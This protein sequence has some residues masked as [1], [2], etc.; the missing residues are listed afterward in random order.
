MD[1]DYMHSSGSRT[2]G[3]GVVFIISV[4]VL[5]QTAPGS[6]APLKNVII[7]SVDTLRADH[8]G[9]Y[10]YP[11]NTSPAIDALSKDGVLF[12]RCFT[13]TPLTTPAFSTML[14]SLSPHR[15]GAK[16]NGLSIFNQIHTLPFYLK[17]HGITSAAFISNWP[18]RK[19]LCGL[20]RDF[21]S[22]TEVF[23]KRRW[24]GILN[25]E[26]EAQDVTERATAWLE[27]NHKKPLF[28]WV[29]FTD[30]HAPYKFHRQHV[31]KYHEKY[32]P[33]YPPGTHYDKIE[34]YDSEIALTDH[35]IGKLLEKIRALGLYRDT[36]I[37][38]NSDHGE[39][40]GEHNYFRHGRKLYNSTLHIPLIVKYPGNHLGGTERQDN[41]CLL[42]IAP[43]ILSALGIPVPD[44]MEGR[45]LQ[46]KTEN[47]IIYFET[48]KGTSLI[49]RSNT[50]KTKV[51]PIRYGLLLGSKKSIYT[52]RSKKLERYDLKT[53]RWELNDLGGG[54]SGGF[55][56]LNTRLRKH[57]VRVV[58][59]IN[60]TRKYYSRSSKLTP[61]DIEKLRSLG[62]I[63]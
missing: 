63:Q 9:C 20:H 44:H 31:F 4:L 59:F 14:T 3:W 25:A 58:N 45:P 50:F 22:Y 30:P 19:N 62:Y 5:A 47:R 51:F 38:F 21:D 10:G 56:N 41:V 17:K 35:H 53:D 43:T 2:G 52:R 34:R 15:H 28:L 36:L 49:K 46:Q 8:L 23:G 11:R 7:I 13:L 60:K 37:I 26:G 27:K 61:E 32:R 54:S 39:S 33:L 29:H 1:T 24:G 55:G 40:F 16:R 6:T 57:V 18:L 48:Y 12:T 42:D